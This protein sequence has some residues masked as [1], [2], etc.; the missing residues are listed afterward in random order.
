M[1]IDNSYISAYLGDEPY[2]F[3]SYAHKDKDEVYKIIKWL[4]ENNYRLW[5]D[6]GIEFGENFPDEIAMKIKDCTHFIVFISNLSIMRDFVK[7]EIH[8]AIKCKKKILPIYLEETLMSPGL[9]FTIG[10][11]Q[12]IEK[13]NLDWNQLCNYLI[14]GLPN[15]CKVMNNSLARDINEN[16]MCESDYK[17]QATADLD[18]ASLHDLRMKAA[19]TMKEVGIFINEI[20]NLP[21][22]FYKDINEIKMNISNF[23]TSIYDLELKSKKD[24]TVNKTL[25]GGAA[26]AGGGAFLALTGPIGWAVG[27]A[28][29][30]KLVSKKNKKNAEQAETQINTANNE[31]SELEKLD[32]K[33]KEVS[34]LVNTHNTYL[35]ITVQELYNIPRDYNKLTQ[36][37]KVRLEMLVYNTRVL[38]ELLNKRVS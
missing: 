22:E 2:L 34:T 23:E 10:T 17:K 12:G 36:D 21:I 13:Y 14:K 20:T 18:V 31:C 6:E 26:I 5:Y 24:T 30:W 1:N 29:L 27:G 28:A 9:D 16:V 11:I 3:I 25:V 19:D 8:Y 7:R 33:V 35:R 4:F 15:E 38:S 37:Q 32:T